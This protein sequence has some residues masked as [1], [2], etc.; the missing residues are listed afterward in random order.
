M[1][2]NLFFNLLLAG[3]DNNPE[4]TVGYNF[5]TDGF[6]KIFCIVL[7]LI[8]IFGSIAVFCYISYLRGKIHDLE[9]KISTGNK[10]QEENPNSIESGKE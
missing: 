8:V 2:K 4:L 10:E 9:E 6:L 1:F 5:D 7:L 3:T